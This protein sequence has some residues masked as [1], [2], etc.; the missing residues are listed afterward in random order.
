MECKSLQKLTLPK[1]LFGSEL[2]TQKEWRKVARRAWKAGDWSNA[3]ANLEMVSAANVD[4]LI[5]TSSRSLRT[6]HPDSWRMY[7]VGEGFKKVALDA[8]PLGPTEMDIFDILLLEGMNWLWFTIGLLEIGGGRFNL[9]DFPRS[10]PIMEVLYDYVDRFAY[11]LPELIQLECVLRDDFNLV[12]TDDSYRCP[13]AINIVSLAADC[14]VELPFEAS[15]SGEVLVESL[16]R[17]GLIEPFED[18]YRAR[19]S[20]SKAIE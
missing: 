13:W 10:R 1:I 17:T 3:V 19:R 2:Y 14:G 6:A 16:L 7:V 4:A 15:E 18:R 5:V 8:V 9:S 12:Q 20:K 11:W